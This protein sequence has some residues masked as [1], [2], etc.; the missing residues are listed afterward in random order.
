MVFMKDGKVSTLTGFI[1]NR[2]RDDGVFVIPKKL[3]R[4]A[5]YEE[6]LW[7]DTWGMKNKHLC[8]RTSLH[9]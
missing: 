9:T 8:C 5:Q 1:T 6:V 2:P 7:E 3:M 4:L